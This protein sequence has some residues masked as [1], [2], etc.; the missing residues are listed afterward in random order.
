MEFKI[1]AVTHK[2][3]DNLAEGRTF[4][5]VGPN[6]NIENV[7]VFDNTLDNINEKNPNFC[8]LT[9]LYW[10]W[11]NDNSDYVGLEHYRRFFSK[12]GLFSTRPLRKAELLKKL[13]KS[14]LIIP[15]SRVGELSVEDYYKKEHY[16]EDLYVC[17][18]IISEKY[19]EYLS[20]FDQ[21]MKSKRAFMTNM[22]VSKKSIID[23]YSNWLFDILFEAER[24]IDISDRDTYQKRIFGFLSERLFNVYIIKNGL[25]VKQNKIND[26]GDKGYVQNRIRKIKGF[27]CK[28]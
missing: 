17:R 22:F 19:P 2:K 16:V 21:V 7:E 26:F 28:K 18:D 23:A 20:A 5:G 15:E 4:I 12:K 27:F 6:K 13:K 14:D 3:V 25:K 11:K 9:A 1:F 10:I 8:E 24:R